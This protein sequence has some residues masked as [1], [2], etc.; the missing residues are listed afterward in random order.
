MFERLVIVLLLVIAGLL[1]WIG[2]EVHQVVGWQETI[3]GNMLVL[4]RPVR[5]EP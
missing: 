3:N 2:W 4:D 5:F 1:G